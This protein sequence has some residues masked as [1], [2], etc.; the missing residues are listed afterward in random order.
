MNSGESSGTVNLLAPLNWLIANG[1]EE[2][3]MALAEIDYG[4]EICSTGAQDE[5]FTMNDYSLS[6]TRGGTSAIAPVAY[7][8]AADV[9]STGATLN[10]TVNPDGRDTTYQFEYGTTN[11]FGS[12][13]PVSPA[14]AGP[15]T[16]AE[17]ET[18]TLTGLTP[19]TVYHY[20]IEATNAAGT[21]HGQDQTFT[22]PA[23][24]GTVLDDKTFEDGTRD[25]LDNWYGET[26]HVTT[27]QAHLGT[28]SLE[29]EATSSN[30]A[31]SDAWPGQAQ[32]TP[33]Q[34]VLFTGWLKSAAGSADLTVTIKWLGSDGNMV[35]SAETIKATDDPS[36]WTE[37]TGQF[38]PPAGATSAYEE[39]GSVDGGAHYL[40]D[41]AVTQVG[42]GLDLPPVEHGAAGNLAAWYTE[43]TQQTAG[44]S[45]T[46]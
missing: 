35:G 10:G 31:V 33:G 34:M 2:P 9:T 23:G 39:L 41:L 36:R 19:G 21:T 40:D 16:A 15:G 25:D 5:T 20:R 4:W 22:T 8:S 32:V 18:A 46:P 44:Q 1:Y 17:T 3:D 37:F 38:T 28:H 6:A 42:A 12:S 30:W 24:A 7:A 45:T 27:S 43:T 26:S 29:I 13:S 14:G 11:S